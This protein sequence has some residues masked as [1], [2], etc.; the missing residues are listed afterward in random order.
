MTAVSTNETRRNYSALSGMVQLDTRAHLVVITPPPMHQAMFDKFNP[1]DAEIH[2][3]EEELAGVAQ[4]ARECPARVT[5]D[6]HRQFTGTVADSFWTDDGVHPSFEG[7]QIILRHIVQ[8][9]AEATR[10]PADRIPK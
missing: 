3:K 6:L 7:H 2:W 8:A 4:L 1:A 5:I 9:L 10:P